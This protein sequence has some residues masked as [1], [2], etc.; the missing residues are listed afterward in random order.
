MF[1]VI[2]ILKKMVISILLHNKLKPMFS[3]L[4]LTQS[5]HIK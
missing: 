2:S 1:M 5:V 4:V 3:H